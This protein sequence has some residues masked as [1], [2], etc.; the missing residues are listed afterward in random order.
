MLGYARGVI[1]SKLPSRSLAQ[2]FITLPRLAWYLLIYLLVGVVYERAYE[3][4]GHIAV[5][6]DL[7]PVQLVHVPRSFNALVLVA[8]F[9]RI[10]WLTLQH[11]EVGS[12]QVEAS[13]YLTHEA[14]Y[15]YGLV[16]GERF[17]GMG[18]LQAIFADVFNVHGMV[19]CS[20]STVKIVST[21]AFG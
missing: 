16:E 17:I 5:E 6:V 9:Q 13:K 19:V 15:Q 18:L 4:F 12:L 8:Q 1:V 3:G 2:A 10:V 7:I 14:K 21:K 20:K 11:H